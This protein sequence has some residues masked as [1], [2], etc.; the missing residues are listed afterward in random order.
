MFFLL[1]NYGKKPLRSVVNN[2]TEN[3]KNSFFQFRLASH[4]AKFPKCFRSLSTITNPK[5]AIIPIIVRP[6]NRPQSPSSGTGDSTATGTRPVTN[7]K[8]DQK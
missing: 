8:Q 7:K 2:F 1:G 5:E 6:I 4:R 3:Y